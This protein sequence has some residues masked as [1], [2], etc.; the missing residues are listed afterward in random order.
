[1]EKERGQQTI[2]KIIAKIKSNGHTGRRKAERK[3]PGEKIRGA[4]GGGRSKKEGAAKNKRW[5][6]ST[7]KELKEQVEDQAQ[8]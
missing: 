8:H 5:R 6:Q 7:P 1:M 4:D 2:K 3:S